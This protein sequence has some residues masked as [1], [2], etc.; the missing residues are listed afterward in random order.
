MLDV[1]KQGLAGSI[2]GTLSLL[3]QQTTAFSLSPPHGHSSVHVHGPRE[4]SLPSLLR[5]TLIL[6]YQHPTLM[7]LCLEAPSS[8][9]TALGIQVSIYEFGEDTDIQSVTATFYMF[10]AKIESLFWLFGKD[11]RVLFWLL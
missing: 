11:N 6:T 1:P 3:G 8:N 9:I 4:D 10:L 7:T 5:R 2:S